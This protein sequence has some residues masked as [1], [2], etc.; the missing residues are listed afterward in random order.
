MRY[1]LRRGRRAGPARAAARVTSAA[2]AAAADGGAGYPVPHGALDVSA[3]PLSAP[4]RPRQRPSPAP[5]GGMP[6]HMAPAE[7]AQ[8]VPR[9]NSICIDVPPPEAPVRR[10]QLEAA[11]QWLRAAGQGMREDKLQ[12]LYHS[13]TLLSLMG[14]MM[15]EMLHLRTLNLVGGLCSVAFY[16]SRRPPVWGAVFW[17]LVFGTANLIMLLRLLYE[18]VQVQKVTPEDADI[19]EAYFGKITLRQSLRLLKL[20]KRTTVPAGGP[21]RTKGGVYSDLILLTKGRAEV[22]WPQQQGIP[23]RTEEATGWIGE[24]GF[25]SRMRRDDGLDDPP[26]K[27]ATC[28]VVAKTRCE[29]LVW[30]DDALSSVLQEDPKLRIFFLHQLAQL[31]Q[32]RMQRQLDDVVDA[33]P[34]LTRYAAMLEA[35]LVDDRVTQQERSMIHD[36]RTKHNIDPVQH[37]RHL[38]RFGW[39]EEEWLQGAKKGAQVED[40]QRQLDQGAP[41][42]T[43]PVF[44]S[45]FTRGHGELSTYFPAS[46]RD[47]SGQTWHSAEHYYQASKFLDEETRAKIRAAPTALKARQFGS[48]RHANPGS[49][50]R[51]D[52][53]FVREDILLQATR[54]KFQQ[55]EPCRRALLNTGN[56][57]LVLHDREDGFWG[58]GPDDKGRNRLGQILMTVRAELRSGELVPTNPPCAPPAPWGLP[59]D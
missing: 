23:A 21:I 5:A 35:V 47:S 10:T 7:P 46:F 39:T 38:E 12:V 20:A 59:G 29:M 25:L 17:G 57:C 43:G 32:E 50:F 49:R 6:S 13:G 52:W 8:Q 33:T 31:A 51:S 11:A 45:G 2:N 16:Y 34:N 41:G 22:R 36:F 48:P 58:S 27:G 15:S 4:R 1:A 26:V 44:F 56:R 9:I 30:D 28:E 55:S 14:C 37:R 19:I 40:V 42:E 24:M 53:D 54:L 18:Q 3:V